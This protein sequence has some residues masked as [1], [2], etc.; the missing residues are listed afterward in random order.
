MKKIKCNNENAPKTFRYVERELGGLMAKVI[1]LKLWDNATV[2]ECAEYQRAYNSIKKANDKI[3]QIKKRFQIN[4]RKGEV[5]A[6]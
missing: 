2:D 1:G 5:V 3:Y 4:S 6:A